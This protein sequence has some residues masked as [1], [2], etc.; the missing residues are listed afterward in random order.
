[1]SSQMPHE[2]VL[3]HLIQ[4]IFTRKLKPGD[5]LLPVRHL[6]EEMGVD[7]ASVRIALKQLEIMNVL[8]IRRG[9]GA[10]VK[11]YMKHAGIEFLSA[12]ILQQPKNT[13]WLLDEYMVDELWE[14][15]ISVLPEILRLASEKHSPRDVKALMDI[16]NDEEANL[17]D[18]QKIVELQVQAQ[19]YVAQVANNMMYLLLFNSSRPLRI[20]LTELFVHNVDEKRL[21]EFIKLEKTILRQF[22]TDSSRNI[23]TITENYRKLLREYRL[24]M[25]QIFQEKTA[26]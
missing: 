21:K 2:K 7:Q 13:D 10:Y 5:K 25:R 4:Q 14:F 26:S 8:H 17:H 18:R 3:N 15:W 1:M 12:S 6:V 20:K 23:H 9:D 19:D 16:L 22:M 11:D 24:L